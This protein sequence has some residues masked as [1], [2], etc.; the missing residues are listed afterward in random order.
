MKGVLCSG[1]LVLDLLARPVDRLEWGA[2]TLIDSIAQHL[3]GNGA[4]TSFTIAKLGVPVRVLGMVGAD[5]FGDFVLAELGGAGVDTRAV[6]RSKAPT[7][8]TVVLVNG[9][10]ERLLLHRLGAS[11]EVEF[12]PEEMA[13]EFARGVSRYHMGSP[14]G[15]PR[16]RPRQAAILRQA[17]AAGLATSI[18]THW[19]ASGRWLEDLAPCLPHTD[20]LFANR[21]EAR[22]LTGTAAPEEAARVLL[23]HGAGAVAIKLG[24]EGC[25]V[26]RADGDFRSPGFDVPVVDTTGAGDCFAG[27]FLAALERG[28]S[29]ERAARV[30]NA[31]GALS[32]QRLGAVEGVLSWAET[33]RWIGS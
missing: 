9:A 30:A 18:D 19:D 20:I 8:A 15:L 21:D 16:L 1:N 5:R 26:F 11:V 27:G 6:R 3:G 7:A 10:G 22:M 33:E 28:C 29:W 12:E 2:T 24:R 13:R 32:T 14:F 23:A 17:R 31:A 4:N 25:A